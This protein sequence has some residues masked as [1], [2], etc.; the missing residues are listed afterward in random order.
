MHQYRFILKG[1]NVAWAYAII[2][3]W[4]IVFR[5]D[6][7]YHG[8]VTCIAISKPYESLLCNQIIPILQQFVA[9]LN[10]IIFVQEGVPLQIAKP[11]M[12]LLKKYFGNDKIISCHFPA[13]C[14]LK[15]LG[16]NL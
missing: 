3:C 10:K 6:G 2:Y 11:L 14:P 4:G 15:S 7:S 9:C 16:L 8:H 5:G 12:K 1:N 13:T